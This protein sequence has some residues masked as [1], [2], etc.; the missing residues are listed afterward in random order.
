MS[1]IK[2][3]RA[4]LGLS[5]TPANNIT[6]DSSADNGTGRIYQGN[7]GTPVRDILTW[8]AAGKPD[9]AQ[10]ARSIGATG[11][12]ELPGGLIIKWGVLSASGSAQ[13]HTFAT[14]FPSA[15]YVL[16]VTNAN[17]VVAQ[18]AGYALGPSGFSYIGS[19]FVYWIAIGK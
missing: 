15:G 7:A 19:G 3:I 12:Y 17:N 6:I 18:T 2:S 14:P 8:D 5:L 10:L 13:T 16:S 4:Q 9:F 1:L 11:S